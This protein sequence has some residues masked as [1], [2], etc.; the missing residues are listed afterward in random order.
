MATVAL[1][2]RQNGRIVAVGRYRIDKGADPK[3][4]ESP[5]IEIQI[6]DENA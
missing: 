2:A 4:F 3:L 5:V 6:L 1:M